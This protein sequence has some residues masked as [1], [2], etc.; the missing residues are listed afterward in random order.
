MSADLARRANDVAAVHALFDL[1]SPTGSP[2]P[3]D[4]FTVGDPDQNTGRR[5]TLPMSAGCVAHQSDC[6]DLG[7]INTLD[8]F[9]MQPRLSIPFDG[10]IAINSVTNRTV[11]LISLGDALDPHDSGGQVVGINQ[12]VWDTFTNTL[13]VASD[14][15]LN[16]HARYAL[17]VT[18]GVRDASGEPVEAS[19]SFRRFRSQVRG[20][21]KQELLDAIHAARRI[22]VGEDEIV[23]ASV[24]TTQSSTAV[25]EQIR[26]EIKAGTPEWADFNLGPRGARTVFPRSQMTGITFN[27]QTRVDG[28]LDPVRLPVESLDMLGRV[29]GTI[30]FGK[31]VSPDYMVH[32][33]EFIPPVGTRTGSPQV[34]GTNEI[35]FTL[36]LPS[37]ARPAGGWPVAIAG[38]GRGGSKDFNPPAEFPWNIASTLAAHGIATII[39]NHAGHGFGP[40][41]TLT[42]NQTNGTSVTFSAG[43]RGIDQNGDGQIGDFEGAESAPPR[44][45]QGVRDGYIQTVADYMQMVRVIQVGM[46]VDGDGS[47]DLD[48]SR[49]YYVGQSQGANAGVLF[50]AVEPDVR[51]ATMTG[52]GGP[53]VENQRSV[54]GGRPL[55]A[56]I[57]TT[58]QP[59][60]LI[61]PGI[62]GIEGV[63]VPAGPSFNENMPLRD[64]VPYSVV[65]QDGTTQV[66]QSPVIN[67]VTGAMAIQEW[68]DRAAWAAQ[69]SN[70]VA[71]APHLRQRPLPS[72]SARP[73]L[74]QFAKGD[75]L[76]NNPGTTAVLRAGD[77][78]DR[79]TLYRHDLACAENPTCRKPGHGFMVS[80]ALFGA[81][82]RGAQEQI[83]T[84]FASDG[85][86]VIHPEPARFFEVPISSPL[87]EDLGYIR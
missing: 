52:A 11:F 79:A 80:S 23:T 27:Q 58:R 71:Y 59:S 29:V 86:L 17:I 40:L 2:F 1:S 76:V 4:R 81:V 10:S 46:D 72:V 73:V 18:T 30:A 54:Q 42:V 39:I 7:V 56:G 61:S 31:Y 16:Q 35:Y 3:S 22:G 78:A 26:D 32:P 60:L 12:V 8:G 87:P 24:F 85:T 28:P 67:T 36:Y 51:A 6:E 77:L 9:N 41:G 49:L 53:V 75:Q 68:I 13:H 47:V 65:L 57:L 69:A 64:S 33:G 37:G 14:E 84:F 55:L 15:L 70:P 20:E 38:H 34:Q 83:A 25:L 44:I 63:A 21:Y 66:I 48:A 45:L 5:V 43:G 50:M 19:E 62:T 74:F 82:S